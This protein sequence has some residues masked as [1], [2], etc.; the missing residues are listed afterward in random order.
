MVRPGRSRQQASPRQVRLDRRAPM[1]VRARRGES[2]RRLPGDA[3][4]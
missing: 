1:C 4:P 2:A 3:G